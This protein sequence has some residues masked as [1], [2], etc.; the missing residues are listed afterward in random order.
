MALPSAAAQVALAI[1]VVRPL[2]F[3]VVQ[4]LLLHCANSVS[5]KLL[6]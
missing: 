1:S 5:I 2:L 6:K 3:A 4:L